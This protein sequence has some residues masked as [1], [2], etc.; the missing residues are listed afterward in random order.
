MLLVLRK[1]MPWAKELWNSWRKSS[2]C[3]R[4]VLFLLV[5][6]LTLKKD[7]SSCLIASRMLSLLLQHFWVSIQPSTDSPLDGVE[8]LIC[9]SIED[10]GKHLPKNPQTNDGVWRE[11]TIG[12]SWLVAGWSS[13]WKSLHP[14][15]PRYVDE[16]TGEQYI[17][18]WVF[19]NQLGWWTSR[20]KN[21]LLMSVASTPRFYI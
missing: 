16:R 12:W 7:R 3:K 8:P 17:D 14:Q 2:S 10:L 4:C 6:K 20:F 9:W 11:K 21:K 13:S 18:R 15:T 1:W 5:F 19:L